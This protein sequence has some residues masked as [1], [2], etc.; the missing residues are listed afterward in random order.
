MIVGEYQIVIRYLVT[1][2]EEEVKQLRRADM[3]DPNCPIPLQAWLTPE[4]LAV[5]CDRF[6]W[7]VPV[8]LATV[9]SI[10]AIARGGGGQA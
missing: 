6:G 10:T 4:E 2:N 3:L 5:I 7:P 1:Y 9:K 8:G